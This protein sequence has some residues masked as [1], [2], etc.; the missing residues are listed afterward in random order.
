LKS[1]VCWLNSVV[2][3]TCDC[4]VVVLTPDRVWTTQIV[5]SELTG[6]VYM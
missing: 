5:I 2:V 4:E 1:E 6:T 3:Q